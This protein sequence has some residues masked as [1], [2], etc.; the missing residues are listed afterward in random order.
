MTRLALPPNCG[1]RPSLGGA[2]PVRLMVAD[3][4]VASWLQTSGA[5][6]LGEVR[7]RSLRELRNLECF[8]S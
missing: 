8:S 1:S 2:A 6:A 5:G 7:A 3:G 4:R